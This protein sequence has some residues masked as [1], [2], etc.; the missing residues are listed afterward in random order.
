MEAAQAIAAENARKHL[1]LETQKVVARTIRNIAI[2]VAGSALAAF[3]TV[4]LFL[5]FLAM[6]GH[7]KALRQ[8]VETLADR[9]SSTSR[10]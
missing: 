5:A 7:S 9:N 10:G 8:A 4:A 3:L 6:E 2:G 1:E